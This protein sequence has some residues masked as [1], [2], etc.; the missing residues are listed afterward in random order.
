M[1]KIINWQKYYGVYPVDVTVNGLD[2]ESGSALVSEVTVSATFRY[3][4]KVTNNN[5]TL[6]EFNFN[7]GITDNLGRVRDIKFTEIGKFYEVNNK[8]GNNIGLPTY[9]GES[10]MFVGT[11]FIVLGLNRKDPVTKEKNIMEPY[12][13]FSGIDDVEICGTANASLVNHY[14]SDNADII[15]AI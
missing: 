4:K 14:I 11:P 12:L 10:D 6:V 9:L 13:K 1:S 3:Q 15:G 7:A 5:K 2:G 8:N